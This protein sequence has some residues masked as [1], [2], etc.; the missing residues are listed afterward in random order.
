MWVNLK[1]KLKSPESQLARLSLSSYIPTEHLHRHYIR[2]IKELYLIFYN[3]CFQAL[4]VL[5]LLLS[6]VSCP[7]DEPDFSWKS[8]C[9]I[10]WLY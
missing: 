8:D 9:V 5:H 4:E 10:D 7:V 1:V 3:I 2:Y 6:S